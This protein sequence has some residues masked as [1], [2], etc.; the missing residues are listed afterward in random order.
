MQFRV[1][2]VSIQDLRQSKALLFLPVAFLLS[3]T[4]IG[5]ASAQTAD[6]EIIESSKRSFDFDCEPGSLPE[7]SL[8]EGFREDIRKV[9]NPDYV[10]KYP[11]KCKTWSKSYL[12]QKENGDVISY[13]VNVVKYQ[14]DDQPAL[15]TVVRGQNGVAYTTVSIDDED[16]GS[17]N[18]DG[19]IRTR[20]SDEFKLV[21]STANADLTLYS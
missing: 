17:T 3:A 15:I 12:V 14:G 7:T 1:S 18:S 9:V 8:L 21:V 20:L 5:S 13:T 11:D 19:R 4:L 16:V 2:M 10:D 6:N